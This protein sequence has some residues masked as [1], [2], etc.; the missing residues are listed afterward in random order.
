[1]YFYDIPEEKYKITSKKSHNHATKKVSKGPS[2]SSS[3]EG[4]KPGLLCTTTAGSPSF[5][6]DS[7]ADGEEEQAHGLPDGIIFVDFPRWIMFLEEN[8]SVNACLG[9]QL[10][11]LMVFLFLQ[12]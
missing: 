11:V 8:S 2:P 5:L 7:L 12:G 9:I 10:G 1:V 3:D 6:C 4:S